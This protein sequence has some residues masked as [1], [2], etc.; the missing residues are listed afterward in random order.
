MAG[1]SKKFQIAMTHAKRFSEQG[2]WAEAIK[3]YR[4]ALAE[5]PNDQGA[6]IGFGQATL[7]A[8][9]VDM[10]RKAFEQALK[11]DPGNYQVLHYIAEIQEQTGRVDESAE[12]HLRVGNILAAQED[13]D[14]A[15]ESWQRA[16]NLAPNH[17]DANHKIDKE[18][19]H[20]K[21]RTDQPD[22]QD[23]LSLPF[24]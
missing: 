6:I 4:F 9:K 24:H 22:G 11:L 20:G 10:S 14:G 16:T 1:D 23:A 19:E 8:G 12:T 18:N 5:F 3:A 21:Q 7:S 15:I 2:I 13:L 17:I